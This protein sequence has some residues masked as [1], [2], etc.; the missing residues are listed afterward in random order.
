MCMCRAELAAWV[1]RVAACETVP[2]VAAT[3]A[4]AT[5]ADATTYIQDLTG[6]LIPPP[7]CGRTR[8]GATSATPL[9]PPVSPWALCLQWHSALHPSIVRLPPSA[10]ES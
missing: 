1:T 6:F 10:L 7:P 3:G 4:I 2:L 8:P 9:A 5:A